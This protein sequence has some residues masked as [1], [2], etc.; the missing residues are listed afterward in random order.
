MLMKPVIT[1]ALKDADE[2]LRSFSGYL[3]TDHYAG[4]GRVESHRRQLC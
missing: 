2:L 1:E 3:V 4:Y